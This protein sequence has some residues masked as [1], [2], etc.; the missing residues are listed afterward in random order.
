MKT[1]LFSILIMATLL[2]LSACSKDDTTNNVKTVENKVTEKVTVVK[3][4]AAEVVDE[5]ETKVNHTSDESYVA[6]YVAGALKSIKNTTECKG[7]KDSIS[8]VLTEYKAGNVMDAAALTMVKE[9][10]NADKSC[11]I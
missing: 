4:T 3:E 10:V 9:S 6:G 1:K 8:A 7:V 2:S 11:R 5:I